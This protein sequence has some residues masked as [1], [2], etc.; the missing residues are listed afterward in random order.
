M[1]VTPRSTLKRI[2]S[3]I[4]LSNHYRN[5]KPFTFV[6]TNET[7]S[8]KYNITNNLFAFKSFYVYV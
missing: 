2:D 6:Q 4:E 8:F 3:H 5:L 1:D 7:V